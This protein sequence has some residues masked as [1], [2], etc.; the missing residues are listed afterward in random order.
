MVIQGA[1]DEFSKDTGVP[2]LSHFIAYMG[3]ILSI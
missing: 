1:D 3:G 2:L